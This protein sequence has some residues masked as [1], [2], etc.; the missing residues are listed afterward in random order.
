MKTREK[1]DLKLCLHEDWLMNKNL[2]SMSFKIWKQKLMRFPKK[3]LIDQS[4]IYKSSITKL[5]LILKLLSYEKKRNWIWSERWMTW[6]ISDSPMLFPDTTKF[7]P[8][9]KL[10]KEQLIFLKIFFHLSEFILQDLKRRSKET[11]VNNLDNSWGK[12]TTYNHLCIKL[13]ENL[14][15]SARFPKKL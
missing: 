10:L 9:K 12:L 11:T 5:Q 6:S 14:R 4:S 7:L 1:I 8:K 15:V 13:H 3:I 2:K